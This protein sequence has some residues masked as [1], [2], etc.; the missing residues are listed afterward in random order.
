MSL[1]DTLRDMDIRAAYGKFDKQMKLPYAVVLGDGQQQIFADNTIYDKRNTY[2]VEYYFQ[3]K[4]SARE[5]ALEDGLLAAGYIYDK[6]EDVY[7]EDERVFVIYYTVWH[8]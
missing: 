2:T 6:S 3:S 1:V 4:S 8:K 7:I 5:D